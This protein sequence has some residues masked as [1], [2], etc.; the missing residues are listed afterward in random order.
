[1]KESTAAARV[2]VKGK[3]DALPAVALPVPLPL[4]VQLVNAESDLC[5]QAVYE[6]G[7]VRMNGPALFRARVSN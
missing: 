1:M 7:D 2:R 5:W 4:T 6:P 3:G